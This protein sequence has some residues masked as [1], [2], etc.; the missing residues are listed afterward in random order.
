MLP[1]IPRITPPP[2]NTEP[3]DTSTTEVRRLTGTCCQTREKHA[4]HWFDSRGVRDWDINPIGIHLQVDALE[5]PHGGCL[6]C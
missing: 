3:I 5:Q 4:Q 2:V 1:V 6:L